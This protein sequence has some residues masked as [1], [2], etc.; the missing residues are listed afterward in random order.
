MPRIICHVAAP[1]NVLSI[2]KATGARMLCPAPCVSKLLFANFSSSCHCWN[3]S[4]VQ[5][6]FVRQ[7][8]PFPRD[9]KTKF[10]KPP[11]KSID[12]HVVH[13]NPNKLV[14]TTCIVCSFLTPLLLAA[15]RAY[16]ISDWCVCLS[17]CLSVC[18]TFSNR[19]FSYSFC[20]IL[21]KLGTHNLCA[22]TEKTL[23]QIFKIFLSKFW[24]NF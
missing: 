20:P 3:M 8:T 18:Q 5:G 9:L 21:M 13:H 10:V 4:A 1:C 24:A 23:D 16:S 17:V 7:N 14:C 11:A 22:N 19:Y 15:G 6:S 2:D 12:G